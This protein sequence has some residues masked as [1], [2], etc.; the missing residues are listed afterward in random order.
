MTGSTRRAVTQWLLLCALFLGV[1]GMHHVATSG[2]MASVDN[3][4]RVTAH[5]ERSPEE[6]T[7]SPEHDV[8]HL[9]VAVLCAV[10]S[11]LLL[12]WL[13]VRTTPPRTGRALGSSAWSRAPVHPPPVGGRALLSS[14]CVLRL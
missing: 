14:V 4:T 7:P 8:L 1:V 5:H 12:A 2:E 13:L 11:L 9:C 6:P 3:M 10:V